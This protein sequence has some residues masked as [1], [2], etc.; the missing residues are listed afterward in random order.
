MAE[1]FSSRNI[2]PNAWLGVTVEIARTKSRIDFIRNLHAP[3]RFISCEPL[4][5]DLGELDLIGINWVIVGGESGVQARPMKEEWVLNIKK[6]ADTLH[7]P[8]FFK[9]WGTWSVDGIK[10]NKKL[11]ANFYR[12]S[13]FRICQPLKS[14]FLFR[15][16]NTVQIQTKT[17]L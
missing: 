6:Q 2:P 12:E 4:L 5:E 14:N 17:V 3:I 7:I 8:F 16:T 11:T 1:Y 15:R 9:Q 10:G 13:W